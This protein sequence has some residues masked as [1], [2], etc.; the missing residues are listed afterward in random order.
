MAYFEID[1]V[2]ESILIQINIP[3]FDFG[4][5]KSTKFYCNMYVLRVSNN[6]Y[7]NQYNT[8][9]ITTCS[10]PDAS[11]LYQYKTFDYDTYVSRELTQWI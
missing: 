1:V 11:V 2:R 5:R 7:N 9:E 10:T 3:Q 8:I 4:E 6:I